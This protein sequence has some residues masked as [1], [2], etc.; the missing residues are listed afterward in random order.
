M[1]VTISNDKIKQLSEKL[2]KMDLCFH[3][4]DEPY[5]SEFKNTD[6]LAQF[7]FIGNAINF[8]FW[9]TSCKSRYEFGEY[10]GSAAMWSFLRNNMRLINPNYIKSLEIENELGL[11]LMPMHVERVIALREAG[12]QLLKCF[13][14]RALEICKYGNWH[15]PSIVDIIINHFPTWRDEQRD[16]KFNKRAQ[17]FVSMLHGR[18]GKESKFTGINQLTCLA[19]YQLPKVL[20]HL[21][22]LQYSKRLENMIE[23]ETFISEGSEDEFTIRVSTIDAVKMICDKLN[24]SN[25]NVNPAQL[26]YMLW[27]LAKDI[28]S[29]HHLTVTMAY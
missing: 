7:F 11:Q 3:S 14:G 6:Q 4:W 12:Q 19:D 10:S 1:G 23:S 26:D 16:V 8:R 24:S 18:L 9:Q 2:S 5:F 25:I 27:S 20:R 17:L 28:S 22:V 13:N 29:P 15:A 21:G